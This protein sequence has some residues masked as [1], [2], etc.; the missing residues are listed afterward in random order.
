MGIEN[1][2]ITINRVPELRALI[3]TG[4]D[5]LTLG[6]FLLTVVVFA[7]GTWAT[8]Y[9]FKKT[10]L[11]QEKVSKANALKV[12][13]Q[14][15]INELRDT[16]SEFISAALTVQ[17][18]CNVHELQRALREKLALDKS[19]EYSRIISQWTSDHV[20]AMADVNR[21]KAKIQLLSNPNEGNFIAL[22]GHVETA[23]EVCNQDGNS[24]AAPCKLI[25]EVTQE[26]LKTEWERV[27]RME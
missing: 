14:D 24:A 1:S 5:W 25:V 17:R 15:W 2:I 6:G 21:L 16:C 4:T 9:N 19:E 10:I 20:G 8:I 7:L 18:L 23:L 11:S 26:I 22:I 27:K 13:R 12:S 3:D